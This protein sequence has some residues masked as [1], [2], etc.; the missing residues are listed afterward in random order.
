MEPV[1]LGEE[2]V[3]ELLDWERLSGAL[4]TALIEYSAGRVTQP[5]R[6]VI[7]TG[8]APGLFALMPAVYGDVMGAKLVTVYPQNS[9]RGLHTHFGVIVLFRTATGEPLAILDGRLITEMRTAA[10]SALATDLLAA[11]DARILAILGSGVQA[12]SHLQALGRVRRFQ[13]VRVWSRT[14]EHATRFA[15][16]SGSIAVATAEDAVRG[17]DVVVTVTAATEPVL[18]GEWLK[19]GAHVNAIGAIGAVNRELDDAA[20]QNVVVVES[21]ESAA[22]ESAEVMQSGTTV[23]AELG[24]LLSGGRAIPA[25]ATTVYKSLGIAIEDIAAAALVY[26]A[27]GG[28]DDPR[29]T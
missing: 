2:R 15:C 17:A 11:P 16:Q 3:R 26:H 18:R 20:M 24:E 14:M 7:S 27:H 13:E 28:S 6:Q 23:Y 12:R 29:R 9:G 19:D 5:L 22:R 25:Q 4:K 8:A 10:V 1:V 21:R